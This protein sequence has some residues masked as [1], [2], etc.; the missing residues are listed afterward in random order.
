VLSGKLFNGASRSSSPER[1]P[2]PD[3]HSRWPYTN[4]DYASPDEDDDGDDDVLAELEAPSAQSIGMGPGRTGVKGVLRDRDEMQHIQSERQKLA[5]K[6]LNERMEKTNLGGMTFLEEEAFDRAS[7][8]K[9][10][11]QSRRSGPRNFGHLREV[12]VSNFANAI[13]NE[14]PGTW[15]VVHI[16]DLVRYMSPN[17]R[18]YLNLHT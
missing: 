17:F 2:S 8:S 12:G 18:P 3:A 11:E 1:S 6:E 7:H 10:R 16:F 4:P 13:D 5:V 14:E 9:P 15:V